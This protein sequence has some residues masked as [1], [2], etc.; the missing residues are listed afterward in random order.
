M[1]INKNKNM[2]WMLLLAGMAC[3]ALCVSLEGCVKPKNRSSEYTI[4]IT[5][6]TDLQVILKDGTTR[7]FRPEFTVLYSDQN[8]EK[9][10]RRGNFGINQGRSLD[11]KI[12]TWGKKVT[13]PV[14]SGGHV[15]DGFDPQV[16]QSIEPGRSA[17]YF[18]SATSNVVYA[19]KAI[20][21]ENSIHWEFPQV[22]AGRLS[23][24]VKLPVG[25]GGP[26]LSFEFVPAVTGYYSVGY[27][28]APGITLKEVDEL[29][30]PMIWQEK[31][32]PNMSYLSESFQC[33]LPTAL[34]EQQGVTVGV[35]ADTSEI[36]FEPLPSKNNSTFGVMVRDKNGLARPMLFA[37]VL[38]GVGSKMPAGIPFRFKAHLICHQGHLLETYDYVARS[39]FGFKDYRR[40]STVTLNRAFENIVDYGLGPFSQFMDELRGCNYATDVPG[41]VKNITGLSPLSLAVVTDNEEIFKRRARPMLE[42][43]WSRERFLFST[44]PEVKGDGTS[45][46]L[47][48]PG[49]PMSD[50]TSAYIFSQRRTTCDLRMAEEIFS[51]PLDLCLNLAEKLQG[52]SWQNAM[53]LYKATGEKEYLKKAI[54]GADLYLEKRVVTP[55]VD[56][57]DEASRDMFFWTSYAPQW[58][59]LYLLYELTGEKRF[60]DAAHR[61]ARQYAQFVW[62]CPTIPETRVTVNVG[63]KV[64]RYRAGNKYKDMSAPEEAVD[65]W[66]VSEIGLTPESSGTCNGHRGIYMTQFAPWMMRIARDTKDQFL[67]DIARSA[68]IGRYESF[69]GYHLNAGRTTA[70]EKAD[71]A[72]RS[73]PELNGVTS[74]HFNHPWP[75]AAMI[76]DYLVSDIYYRSDAQIDFPAEYAEGYAYCRSKIYGAQ[77]GHFYDEKNV[78]LFMPKGLLT[79]SNVQINYLAAY[80]N[81]KFYVA[82][83]NQSKEAVTTTLTLNSGLLKLD[84][85]KGYSAKVWKDNKPS[86]SVSITD[87]QV[88]VSVSAEGITALAIDSLS[89]STS[90]QSKLTEITSAW[91]QDSASLDFG[92]GSKAVLFNFGPALQSVYTFTK[93]TGE[94]FKEVTLHY[95]CNG[96]WSALTRESYPFDFTVEVPQGTEEFKFRYEGVAKDGNHISSQE[97]ILKK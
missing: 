60:L 26:E 19:S 27:T 86:G 30:Q 34:V 71:Y 36:P 8:P 51:E 89:V 22:F 16:D 92:G 55:Q 76:M 5:N 75:H 74:L 23:A 93:A 94:T 7:I 21:I 82:L 4:S 80:G 20:S 52:N 6:K 15:M 77:P 45:S 67:H 3:V 53:H 1:P 65:A 73:L 18:L 68:V 32:F 35:L 57:A 24:T 42:Y 72:L 38:G 66:R 50:F 48:G 29:W 12:P 46:K 56:F 40:N 9:Q 47:G 14:K 63:N 62:L 85:R 13:M 88:T 49:A 90:F 97:G 44:N 43:S 33:P 87:G 25:E 41:A 70:H 11:Y 17:D 96:K 58:M 39:Y 2:L 37:P 79:S 84:P 54:E 95:A 10:L 69:P 91:R 81:G 83:A 28:G 61:G 64:P 31:R 59:E 78:W